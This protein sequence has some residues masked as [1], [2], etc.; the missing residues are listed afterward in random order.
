MSGLIISLNI[1]YGLLAHFIGDYL[2]QNDFIANQKT[3]KTWPAVVHV[4]LYSIPFY[5]ILGFSYALLFV[6]VTHFFIDRYR[7]AVY[8]IRLI[9]WNWDKDIDNFGYKDDKPK[10]MSF[11]LMVIYDNIFHIIFNSIAIAYHFYL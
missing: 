1:M 7:L 10:W 4:L 11:W 3:K 9:N 8:W 2:F 6:I 5:F